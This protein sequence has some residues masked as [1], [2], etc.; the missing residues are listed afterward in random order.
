[1]LRNF[2]PKLVWALVF[3]GGLYHVRWRTFLWFR[4]L[5]RLFIG[6]FEVVSAFVQC[7][8]VRENSLPHSTQIVR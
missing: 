7:F 4:V 3:Q 5:V 8:L 1:M 2:F 6:E